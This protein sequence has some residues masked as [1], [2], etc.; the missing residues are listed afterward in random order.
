MRC[1]WFILFGMCLRPYKKIP[2]FLLLLFRLTLI[3][4]L[5]SLLF[6]FVLFRFVFRTFFTL[7]DGYWVIKIRE[8]GC[9]SSFLHTVQTNLCSETALLTSYSAA[10]EENKSAAL[11][12]YAKRLNENSDLSIISTIYVVSKF[13]S[14]HST[15]IL[16]LYCFTYEKPHYLHFIYYEKGFINYGTI[17]V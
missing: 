10:A 8:L 12:I 11:E 3:S 4:T 9:N 7:A 16:R 17:T 1:A 6:R 13:L 15:L 14:V 2:L 5:F